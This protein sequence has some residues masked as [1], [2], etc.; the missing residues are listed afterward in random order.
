MSQDK[1][2]KSTLYEQALKRIAETDNISFKLLGLVPLTSGVAVI[3]LMGKASEMPLLISAIVGWLGALITYYIFRWELRNIQSCNQ[4]RVWAGKLEAEAICPELQNL[5]KVNYPPH[6]INPQKPLL[7]DRK[8]DK[9]KKLEEKRELGWGKTEAEKH[10]Y[11]T[12]IFFWMA[13]PVMAW[14]TGMYKSYTPFSLFY[15]F[16]G[17][18]VAAHIFIAL[19]FWTRLVYVHHKQANSSYSK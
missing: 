17:Y 14:L 5:L 19:A 8:P 12:V 1:V 15:Q 16:Q 2:D 10:L 11:W 18:V 9:E 6:F 4:L 3:G 13:F 7:F